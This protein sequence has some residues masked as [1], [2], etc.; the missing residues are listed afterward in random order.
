MLE[1]DYILSDAEKAAK[2]REKIKAKKF[3]DEECSDVEE[4]KEATLKKKGISQTKSKNV[5]E[6]GTKTSS[7]KPINGTIK[8]AK[9]HS[10]PLILS[11]KSETVK[12]QRQQETPEKIM[13]EDQRQ[14]VKTFKASDLL[15]DDKWLKEAVP[16]TANIAAA[17]PSK[18][19]TFYIPTPQKYAKGKIVNDT[20]LTYSQ[21][22]MTQGITTL[23]QSSGNSL[24]ISGIMASSSKK[25]TV[26][27]LLQ[28]SK[29]IP[30]LPSKAKNFGL[31][32]PRPTQKR[33]I[34]QSREEILRRCN[35]DTERMIGKTFLYEHVSTKGKYLNALLI[36]AVD[37][38][39]PKF[40]E[41]FETGFSYLRSLK[42]MN[43]FTN[44]Q[45]KRKFMLNL[46]RILVDDG[47]NANLFMLLSCCRRK[48][49]NE[50]VISC[51]QLPFKHG[52]C[53][54]LHTFD[55]LG[56]SPLHYIIRKPRL[57]MFL[58]YVF[59]GADLSIQYPD[60]RRPNSFRQCV[61]DH[62]P[63]Y[64][65]Q[66]YILNKIAAL[67]SL[68]INRAREA[69]K[70]EKL[71]IVGILSELH[72]GKLFYPESKSKKI[73]VDFEFDF[74]L[75]CP[76]VRKEEEVV[77][78]I[79]PFEYLLEDYISAAHEPEIQFLNIELKSENNETMTL[80]ELIDGTPK[81]VEA[82]TT[83]FD[84]GYFK[85][86]KSI[87]NN[88]YAFKLLPSSVTSFI[89]G[90][91]SWGRLY[92]QTKCNEKNA[93]DFSSS[94][95]AVQAYIVGSER[96]EIPVDV[97]GQ[98]PEGHRLRDT[99]L[100]GD[101][102]VRLDP[103]RLPEDFSK[104]KKTK[105]LEEASAK[106]KVGNKKK[107]NKFNKNDAATSTPIPGIPVDS[108]KSFAMIQRE[109]KKKKAD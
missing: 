43:K 107:K 85:S 24:S 77:I 101:E 20:I 54:L 59:W 92:L 1:N 7:Q 17:S 32:Y 60:E 37:G 19:S 67:Q 78:M 80:V 73:E 2:K 79:F 52:Y 100:I 88:V 93:K 4:E 61:I 74:K 91:T 16:T 96:K 9:S 28:P 63:D 56:Y 65:M 35:H 97:D 81:Y 44:A 29:I 27:I 84:L 23:T 38:D 75:R 48:N 46:L 106:I 45:L 21:P 51:N 25:D 55:D 15:K 87:F 33:F 70:A 41:L 83:C 86:N 95:F 58:E 13:I 90:K 99:L 18:S 76:A 69:L 71:D 109:M 14:S 31:S 22:S 53:A 40:Q 64:E 47:T 12:P 42:S 72:F 11:T 104:R 62:L 30:P 108:N 105:Y 34:T 5:K 68:F 57:D 36:A 66:N 103:E 6:N 39:L 50:N 49:D 89:S 94:L 82:G 3:S 8:S 102:Y 98:W 26:E 10:K